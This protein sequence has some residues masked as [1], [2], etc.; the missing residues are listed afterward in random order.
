MLTAQL[1]AG[2]IG[3]IVAPMLIAIG[4][5]GVAIRGQEGHVLR[6]VA[7]PALLLLVV[8][9]LLTAALAGVVWQQLRRR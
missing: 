4:V 5:T 8:T 3:N 2:N 7:L 1:A 6:L 9:T